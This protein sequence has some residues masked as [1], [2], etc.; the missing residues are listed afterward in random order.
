MNEY[1]THDNHT[2]WVE[3]IFNQMIASY[4]YFNYLDDLFNRF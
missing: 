2:N 3:F 1:Y 4:T